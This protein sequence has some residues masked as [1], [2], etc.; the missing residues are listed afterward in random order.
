LRPGEVR[1][2]GL[3]KRYWFRSSGDSLERD[4][5]FADAEA[6]EDLEAEET[7]AFSLFRRR[8]ETWALR[9]VTCHIRPGERVGIVGANG[10]GK[11]TLIRILSRTLPPSEGRVEGAG[12]VVPFAALKKPLSLQNDGCDNLRM[13]ARLL[14]IPLDHLEQR[15]PAIIEFSELGALAHEKVGRYSDGSFSR[16]SMA[17]GLLIDADIYLI[18]D[19]FKVGDEVYRLKFEQKFAETV[20]RDVTVIFA[21]NAL[22]KLRHYCRRGLWLDQ[23]RL[24]ADDSLDAVIRR[25]LTKNDEVIEYDATAAKEAG[26]DEKK[27][28]LADK[29]STEHSFVSVSDAVT[30]PADRLQP[31][32]EWQAQ[33]ASAEKDWE[34]ALGR[35]RE[36]IRHREILP[37]RSVELPE[38]STLGT[39]RTLWCL[40]SEGHP[41][42]NSLP[43]ETLFA[44]LVVETFKRDVTVAVRL[45]LDA[46]PTLVFIAE[47]LVP[48]Q[49]AEPG[50]FLFR[51]EIDGGWFAHCFDTALYKLR[52]RIVFKSSDVR[53]MATATVR[54]NVRGDVRYS[55]DEQRMA[56]GGPATVIVQP[57]PAY[58]IAPEDA[59]PS[60]PFVDSPEPAT[61][62]QM[63]DRRPVLRPRLNWMV[64]RVCDAPS[65]QDSGAS[66]SS[67]ET[68]SS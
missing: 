38:K 9:D 49:A 59:Q 20:R 1:I 27:T 15:L 47:P 22:D 2:D 60:E 62:R 64:Y 68:A 7:S 41:I 5:P 48:L 33:V 35:W 55:F 34:T 46:P 6:D 40:N 3:G 56:Y 45:E 57:A 51:A 58:L 31:V 65:A 25:F 30:I 63:I 32:P 16:L 61:R 14:G 53:E 67:L 43:G 42:H 11:S 24:V 37:V 44:E 36:K 26:A 10:A 28:E 54:F 12:V 52:T 50:I 18:D 17:M 29:G 23:G 8:K 21:S 13:L 66:G 39:L 19:I 4:E